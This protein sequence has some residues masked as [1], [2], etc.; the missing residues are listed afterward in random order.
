ML[1]ALQFAFR[2]CNLI[3]EPANHQLCK[4]EE[5]HNGSIFKC[6]LLCVALID[7]EAAPSRLINL[8]DKNCLEVHWEPFT[9]LILH[10]KHSAQAEAGFI[11]F[12][13]VQIFWEGNTNLT[14]FI[15]DYS[16]SLKISSY[17]CSL[18]RICEFYQNWLNPIPP[19]SYVFS[20]YI[21]SPWKKV[22]LTRGSRVKT[23]KVKSSYILRRPQNFAKSLLQIWPV[24]HRTNLR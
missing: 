18:L 1:A 22:F 3:L 10:Q 16:E 15:W 6:L 23:F 2:F 20:C 19:P 12:D 11:L 9:V 14:N 8:V 7:W 13:K 17:F 21:L 24:L 4:R 5:K